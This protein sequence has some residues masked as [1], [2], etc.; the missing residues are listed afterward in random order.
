MSG[1]SLN[2]RKYKLLVFADGNSIH[3]EKWL[4]G[5]C[6]QDNIDLY[7]LTLNP[8][9]IREGIRKIK[10]LKGVYEVGKADV[11]Q[12]GNNFHYLM[13]L[14]DIR[15]VVKELQPDIIN[16]IY[17]T[18]YGTLASLTKGKAYLAHFLVGTDIMVTPDKG[19]F[20]RLLTNFALKSGDLIVSASETIA[21]KVTA[22]SGIPKN[23]QLIQQYGVDDS[24]F[25]FPEKNR[26][27]DFSSNRA[28]VENSN[29]PLLIDAFNRVA[30]KGSLALIGSG[31][32]FEGL[33]R[34][35]VLS[36]QEIS[37][38]GTLDY[39]DNLSVVSGS[40]FF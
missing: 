4:K 31:G 40:K 25:S 21:E 24:L 5:L 26:K 38:L 28:W 11:S 10:K 14:M 3:T 30:G 15:R 39:G 35:K 12:S 32:D 23:S 22:L 17:L 1:S 7:L 9:G 37:M 16:S 6:L 20:Y 36:N 33:I 18:S 2:Q 13:R 29:I 19:F 27:Y 34:K 8:K